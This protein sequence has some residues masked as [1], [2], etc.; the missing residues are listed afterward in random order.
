MRINLD[1][2]ESLAERMTAAIEK[3][4]KRLKLPF[5]R[6][7]WIRKAIEDEIEAEDKIEA[8]LERKNP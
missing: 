4:E 5:S 8:N 1:L 2:P 6:M 7:A 3:A